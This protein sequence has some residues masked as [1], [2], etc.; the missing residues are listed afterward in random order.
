MKEFARNTNTNNNSNTA[1]KR[2]VF[3][4]VSVPLQVQSISPQ[5]DVKNINMQL[6]HNSNPKFKYVYFS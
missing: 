4:D 6:V 5:I 2:F 3:R 1:R